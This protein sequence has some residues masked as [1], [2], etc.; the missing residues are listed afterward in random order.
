MIHARRLGQFGDGRVHSVA[1]GVVAVSGVVFQHAPEEIRDV[2][3]VNRRPVLAPRAE[4]DQIA[5][6]VS[7]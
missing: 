1:D 2:G 7:R 4:D 3:G 5:V 6:V